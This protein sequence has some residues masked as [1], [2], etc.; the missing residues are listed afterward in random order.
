MKGRAVT[1]SLDKYSCRVL[2]P[3][4]DILSDA[5]ISVFIEEIL[6]SVE[7]CSFDKNGCYVI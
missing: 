3:L 7:Q 2:Q 4:L 6:D 1:F 5:D